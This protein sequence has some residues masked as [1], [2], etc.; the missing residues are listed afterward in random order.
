MRYRFEISVPADTPPQECRFALMVESAEQTIGSGAVQIPMSG[1]IGVIVYARVGPVRADLQVLGL[2]TVSGEAQ[3]VPALM[4]MNVG[5]ATGRLSGFI[6]RKIARSGDPARV[7]VF[8]GTDRAVEA[9]AA[10]LS[11]TAERAGVL[12]RQV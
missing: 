6:T 9:G 4:V 7:T 1:R 12:T 3:T 5:T 11:Y 2:K 10:R 8:Y